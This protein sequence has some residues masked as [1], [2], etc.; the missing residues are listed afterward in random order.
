MA[1]KNSLMHLAER[2][3]LGRKGEGGRNRRRDRGREGGG[4][5]EWEEGERSKVAN[6]HWIDKRI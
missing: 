3:L 5:M 1:Q 2:G 6:C 4:G